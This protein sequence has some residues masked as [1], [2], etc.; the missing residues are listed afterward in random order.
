MDM[1]FSR[2]S[3]NRDHRGDQADQLGSLLA[4]IAARQSLSATAR[5]QTERTSGEREQLICTIAHFAPDTRNANGAVAFHPGV[6]G[7][8]VTH[9]QHT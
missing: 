7:A 8:I 6:A 1:G 9:R 5:I 3:R 4:G 2:R